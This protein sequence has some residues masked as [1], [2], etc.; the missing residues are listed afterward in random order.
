M[1]L[2]CLWHHVSSI[3]R[4]NKIF[5]AASTAWLHFSKHPL[6]FSSLTTPLTVEVLTIQGHCSGEVTAEQPLT[7]TV[8][9]TSSWGK[10]N[11]TENET[12]Y[13]F[14]FP[15]VFHKY[16]SD[17]R[18]LPWQAPLPSLSYVVSECQP[19]FAPRR[20]LQAS[21]TLSYTRWVKARRRASGHRSVQNQVK[22]QHLY[23][24]PLV[25]VTFGEQKPVIWK[26][27]KMAQSVR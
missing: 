2:V 6:F 15:T 7:Q 3:E 14:F 11:T 22:C 17:K 20:E 1:D 24:T 5:D 4:S 9:Q 8:K 18:P 13:F 21:V 12:I 25:I 26:G 19:S 23:P 27:E 10:G 16:L